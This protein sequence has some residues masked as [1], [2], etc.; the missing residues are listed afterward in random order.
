MR[1][2]SKAEHAKRADQ[3]LEIAGNID[4]NEAEQA[5][6]DAI[7]SA[8]A[9]ALA[10][11]PLRKTRE[12]SLSRTLRLGQDLW[13][14]VIYSTSP[15]GVL[16]YGADR[17]VLAGI[18]HFAWVQR[19]RIVLFEQVGQLLQYF[20]LD[21]GGNSYN[22]LRERFERLADL[23]IYLR[24]SETETG[25]AKASARQQTFV[26]DK[27]V[28]PTR[29]EVRCARIGKVS[30]PRLVEDDSDR[31]HYGVILSEYFWKHLQE[32]KNHLLLHLDIMRQFIDKPTG[33]DYAC[34]V[35]DRCLRARRWSV[36]PHET[37]ISLFKGNPNESDSKTIKRLQKYHSDIMTITGGRLKAILEHNG[38]FP[39]SSKGGHRKARWQLRVGPSTNIIW[40]GK[41]SE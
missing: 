5:R 14:K 4:V 16:P 10:G 22:R 2:N 17:F 32:G 38:F 11:L 24:F 39:R 6:T 1:N 26:L 9:V 36:V 18:Q 34:Y 35:T 7:V 20:G 25:L 33:W 37:L 29:E 3:L 27:C 19:N 23:A 13:L 31:I 12:Q 41:K 40:S 28:L 8:R 21:R 30:L 15:G